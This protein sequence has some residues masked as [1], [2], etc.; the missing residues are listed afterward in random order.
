MKR[1]IKIGLLAAVAPALPALLAGCATEPRPT[2]GAATAAVV[3]ATPELLQ[4][5][6]AAGDAFPSQHPEYAR[7]D[8]LVGARADHRGSLY[9]QAP[10]TRVVT[11]TEEVRVRATEDGYRVTERSSVRSFSDAPAAAPAWRRGHRHR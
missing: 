1:Q 6:R 10:P 8:H 9:R 3:F 5:R 7:R 11:R 4:A 2:G